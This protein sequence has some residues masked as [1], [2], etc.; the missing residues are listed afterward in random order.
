MRTENTLP[1]VDRL[2]LGTGI[3][4][5]FFLH[6]YQLREVPGLHFDEAW[7]MNH[8]A[9][10]FHG[11]FTLRG[12]SPYTAPWAHYWA[13]LFFSFFGIS[14]R[15]FRF[16]QVLLSLLGIFFLGLSLARTG[17]VRGAAW[18]PLTISLLPGLVFNQ[19]FFIEL[20]GFH[21]FCFGLFC[22]FLSKRW[23]W[24]IGLVWLMG[25]T[26]HILF[27]GVGLSV[28]FVRSLQGELRK[29][30]KVALRVVSL[31]FMAFFLSVAMQIPEKGKAL[32][33]LVSAAG[34]F[35]LPMFQVHR[36]KIA[37]A[38]W[39]PFLL[40]ASLIFLANAFLFLPGFWQ[41]SFT[42]GVEIWKGEG[43]MVYLL[44]PFFGFLAWQGAKAFS[45]DLQMAFLL[46]VILLGAMMLKAAPRY[47]EIPLLVLAVFVSSGLWPQRWRAAFVF[48]LAVGAGIFYVPYF[49][50]AP[51]LAEL[52]FLTLKDS[53][54][55]FLSKQELVGVLGGLGCKLSDINA[56]DSRVMEALIA[57]QQG[58]WPLSDK[59]CDGPVGI[60]TE[61]GEFVVRK[62]P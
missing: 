5:L 45:R 50:L 15:V 40:L 30:E 2:V 1:L 29:E 43:A 13:A 31:C 33:L 7:A 52:K 21:V 17:R 3:I 49:S 44:L 47:Y 23:A 16:S 27:Y 4:L 39:L 51:K 42:K 18:L 62:N 54:R 22:F 10:I 53:S 25:S 41:L 38:N 12:M 36:W 9:R 19:R 24:G 35:F 48:L 32:A 8:A 46:G 26:A 6:F 57:L 14:L 56:V 60:F 34:M 28:V 59:N 20:N 11:E 58:D 37:Q 61:K 55:D